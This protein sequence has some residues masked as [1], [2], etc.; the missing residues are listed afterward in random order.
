MLK[1]L[2]ARLNSDSSKSCNAESYQWFSALEIACSVKRL[3]LELKIG[4][5]LRSLFLVRTSGFSFSQCPSFATLLD[6][7]TKKVRFH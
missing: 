1:L 4:F 2:C 7:T 5:L 3:S 6:P